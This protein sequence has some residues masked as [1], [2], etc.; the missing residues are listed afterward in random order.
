MDHMTLGERLA[1]SRKR[2]NVTQDDLAT[3]VNVS[4]GTIGNW[5]R[6]IAD[7]PFSKACMVAD[8]LG[9]SLDEL[10]GRSR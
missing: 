6:G 4:A 2:A 9:V 3:A 5:E 10:A 8:R 1:I 7:I